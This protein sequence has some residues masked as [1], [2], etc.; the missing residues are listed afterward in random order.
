MIDKKVFKK[1]V[2]RSL[3]G[4]HLIK[5]GQSWYLDGP[6]AIVVLNL[7]KNDWANAYFINIGIWLKALG[8]AEFPAESD[9]HLMHRLDSIF[10]EERDLIR[11]GGSLEPSDIR[12]LDQLSGFLEARVVPFMRQCTMLNGLRRLYDEGRF[13][14]GLVVKEARPLL[15]TRDQRDHRTSL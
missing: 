6:D 14:R 7:Q 15:E 1:A 8:P 12:P 9:C 11:D 2:A 5:K 13:R 10:P 4:A 3:E